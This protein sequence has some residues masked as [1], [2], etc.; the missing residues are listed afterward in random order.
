[1]IKNVFSEDGDRYRLC[2]I[3]FSENHAVNEI[4]L[5]NVVEPERAEMTV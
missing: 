3:K 4:I 2:P 5:K 1:V